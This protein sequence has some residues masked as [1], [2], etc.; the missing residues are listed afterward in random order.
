MPLEALQEPWRSFLADTRRQLLISGTLGLLGL[1]YAARSASAGGT[2]DLSGVAFAAAGGWCAYALMK[3]G[4]VMVWGNNQMT[5]FG[6]GS[7]DSN[8]SNLRSRPTPL[9][10]LRNVAEISASM[11]HTFV[12]LTDDTVFGWVTASSGGR[13]ARE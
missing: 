11:I 13:D 5:Q 9:T 7:R 4:T 12:R 10:A 8:F 6:N 2:Q 3:D 1:P